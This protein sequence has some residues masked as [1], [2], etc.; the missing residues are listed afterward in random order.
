MK[1]T[2]H[3]PALKILAR[4]VWWLNAVPDSDLHNMVRDL[5]SL[6]K[7]ET[8]LN[9]SQ[10]LLEEKEKRLEFERLVNS[11]S[12]RMGQFALRPAMIGDS[13]YI[14]TSRPGEPVEFRRMFS[15]AD[16]DDGRRYRL[17]RQFGFDPIAAN[18]RFAFRAFEETVRKRWAWRLRICDVCGRWFCARVREQDYCPCPA[19]CSQLK[20]DRSPKAQEKR[21]KRLQDQRDRLLREREFQKKCWREKASSG[22][23]FARSKR[24]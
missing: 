2:H 20:Y 9:W 24:N 16:K 5:Q 22:N 18:Q 19:R 17:V 13:F 11:I 8:E 23:L 1:K 4:L 7:L 15:R 12:S 21:K 6:E 3:I 10:P 14:H